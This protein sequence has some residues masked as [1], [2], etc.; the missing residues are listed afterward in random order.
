VCVLCKLQTYVAITQAV[1]EVQSGGRFSGRVEYTVRNSE[2]LTP[3]LLQALQDPKLT[4]PPCI[5]TSKTQM[6]T[7]SWYLKDYQEERG[8]KIRLVGTIMSLCVSWFL[9]LWCGYF[10]QI[11][12]ELQW[13]ISAVT[14]HWT[15][16]D[17]IWCKGDSQMGCTWLAP[18][19]RWFTS[20]RHGVLRE[21]RYGGLQPLYH[22]SVSELW[23]QLPPYPGTYVW[24]VVK[25]HLVN[26]AV[27][28]LS[29]SL[30]VTMEFM[31]YCCG[32]LAEWYDFSQIKWYV[33]GDMMLVYADRQSERSYES[34]WWLKP[35]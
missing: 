28:D 2:L 8:E 7:N 10:V 31:K 1:K 34:N 6:P 27:E 20:G 32:W 17:R 3:G 33:F 4:C 22:L 25:V 15:A 19:Q 14:G 5:F 35:H 23:H 9:D 21:C 26:Q 30:P 13:S 29:L 24:M 16:C 18:K 11:C 12:A